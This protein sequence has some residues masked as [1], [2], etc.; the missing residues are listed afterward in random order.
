MKGRGKSNGTSTVSPPRSCSEHCPHPGGLFGYGWKRHV[1]C[2]YSHAF[3][4]R[5]NDLDH[6]FNHDFDDNRTDHY[7]YSLHHCDVGAKRRIGT[8]PGLRSR[9][10]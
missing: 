3:D 7:D 5:G 9:Y 1:K 6:H 2:R 8:A 10:P 4:D